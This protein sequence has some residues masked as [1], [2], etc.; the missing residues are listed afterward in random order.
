MNAAEHREFL[1]DRIIEILL[2]HIRTLDEMSRRNKRMFLCASN[3]STKA[4]LLEE[5]RRINA[6]RRYLEDQIRANFFIG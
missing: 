2:D 4:I 5:R 3:T 6:K 1:E